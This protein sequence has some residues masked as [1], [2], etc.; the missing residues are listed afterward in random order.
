MSLTLEINA[1]KSWPYTSNFTIDQ[2]EHIG[3]IFKSIRGFG[4]FWGA[5]ERARSPNPDFV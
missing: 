5:M 3:T 4:K 1:L 2:P